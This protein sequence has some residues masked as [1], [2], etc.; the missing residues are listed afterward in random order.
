MLKLS[1]EPGFQTKWS[2]LCIAY[3]ASHLFK[4]LI[5]PGVK[6]FFLVYLF[7]SVFSDSHV[8]DF[9][10]KCKSHREIDVAFWYMNM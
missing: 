8:Y 1:M 4:V 5:Q 7:R 10:Q 3:D 2:Y 9:N 6:E